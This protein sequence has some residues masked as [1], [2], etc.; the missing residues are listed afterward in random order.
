MWKKGT[1]RIDKFL[2]ISRLLKRRSVANSATENGNILV[3][4]KVVKPSYRVKIYDVIEI[5][6]V[7]GTVKI[8]VLDLKET[9]NKEQASSLYE[10]LGD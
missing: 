2:K 6:F 4:G 8:R 3:N 9:V 7:S 5:C 1:M 10:I